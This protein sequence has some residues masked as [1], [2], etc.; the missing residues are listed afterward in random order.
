MI[1]H[2]LSRLLLSAACSRA[3]FQGNTRSRDLL[4]KL[5]FEYQGMKVYPPT[6]VLEPTYLL[7]NP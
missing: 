1:R 6:G 4:I 2:A 3:I 7:R 5:G